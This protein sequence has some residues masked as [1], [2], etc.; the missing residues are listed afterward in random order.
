VTHPA[1]TRPIIRRRTQP[2]S[3]AILERLTA[4]ELG[5]TCTKYIGQ[6][7]FSGEAAA[8]IPITIT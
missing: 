2:S 8:V 6:K 5:V 1:A 4:A 3:T 7:R